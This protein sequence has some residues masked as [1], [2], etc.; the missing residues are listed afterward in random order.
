MN[1]AF[2]S[3]LQEVINEVMQ[4]HFGHS[5]KL[6]D[7][8]MTKDIQ[9]GPWMSKLD[10][11]GIVLSP[12]YPTEH[13]IAVVIPGRVFAHEGHEIVENTVAGKSFKYCRNCK[14]EVL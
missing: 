11:R 8:N 6:S 1:K 7:V 5:F 10:L 12:A 13:K 3:D 2:M 9:D 4:R 14:E